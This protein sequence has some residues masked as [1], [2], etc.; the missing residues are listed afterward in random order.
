MAAI[1]L[2]DDAGTT[3]LLPTQ[4]FDFHISE[5]LH[6]K[7]LQDSEVVYDAHNVPVALK[8]PEDEDLVNMPAILNATVGVE[9]AVSDVEDAF[10]LFG[11]LVGRMKQ[12]L[13][14]VPTAMT[15]DAL[16]IDRTR[17]K[18][19]LLPPFQVSE[20]VNEMNALQ[21]LYEH[22][23]NRAYTQEEQQMIQHAW[24]A[25]GERVGR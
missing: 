23:M 2:M 18:A 8:F 17:N 9:D 16:A 15:I 10:V 7:G 22:A 14:V 11:D 5:A 13:G 3:Y 24:Q 4:D 20:T 19:V 6:E 12:E 21:G 25:A 1:T